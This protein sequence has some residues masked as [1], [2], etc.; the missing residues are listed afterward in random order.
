MQLSCESRGFY[1]R[2]TTNKISH[3]SNLL[4]VAHQKGLKVHPYTWRN[5]NKY[6]LFDYELDPYHEYRKF[7]DLGIDGMFTDF[8]GT[9]HD[10]IVSFEQEEN[11]TDNSVLSNMAS[12]ILPLVLLI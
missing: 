6:L 3:Q 10:A 12:L 5:E 8:S 2:K 1:F 9:A 7:Y 4:E 11:C